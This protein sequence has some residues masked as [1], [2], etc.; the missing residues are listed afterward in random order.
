[1]VNTS[2][3]IEIE[4]LETSFLELLEFYIIKIRKFTN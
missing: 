2:K 1:M 3:L 4:N